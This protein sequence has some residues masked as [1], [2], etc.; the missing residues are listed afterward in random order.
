MSLYLYI[1]L[2]AKAT[3]DYYIIMANTT[4]TTWYIKLNSW[5][6]VQGV[7]YPDHLN[8]FM[9]NINRYK[10]VIM[11]FWFDYLGIKRVDC[12]LYNDLA[13]RT[14]PI[15]IEIAV[16]R[17]SSMITLYTISFTAWVTEIVDTTEQSFELNDRLCVWIVSAPINNSAIEI[18][19][20]YS[21]R[22]TTGQ[23]SNNISIGFEQTIPKVP[24]WVIKEQAGDFDNTPLCYPSYGTNNSGLYTPISDYLL[25]SQRYDVQRKMNINSVSTDSI[26][27]KIAVSLNCWW[28]TWIWWTWIS[29]A[30]SANI[31]AMINNLESGTNYV[32]FATR[33]LASNT[34]TTNDSFRLHRYSFSTSTQTLTYSARSSAYRTFKTGRSWG[35]VFALRVWSSSWSFSGKIL[36]WTMLRQ[37]AATDSKIWWLLIFNNTT[38]AL[39]NTFQWIGNTDAS[40]YGVYWPWY[41]YEETSWWVTTAITCASHVTDTTSAISPYPDKIACLWK[42]NNAWAITAQYDLRIDSFWLASYTVKWVTQ[43]SSSMFV[44]WEFTPDP[45]WSPTVKR[46]F[47]IEYDKDG[48]YIAEHITYANESSE[49]MSLSVNADYLTYILKNV[50]DWKSVIMRKNKTTSAIDSKKIT[51][52]N[53]YFAESVSYD[54][55]FIHWYSTTNSGSSYWF[56]YIPWLNWSTRQPS[57]NFTIES[58]TLPTTPNNINRYYW[59]SAFITQV[60]TNPVYTQTLTTQTLSWWWWTSASTNTVF[61]S[62][63]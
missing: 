22:E 8:P 9:P 24:V 56:I 55:I 62:L 31:S 54:K 20:N 1:W 2:T 38:L 28:S 42:Y 39:T 34:T 18:F 46:P 4:Y 12:F 37:Q 45:V 59:L 63:S 53:V 26:T 5:S 40:L 44:F 16:K 25:T 49:I 33:W 35:W 50:S 58:Y 60:S 3:D 61:K 17:W 21:N 52:M 41:I 57:N 23:F 27:D 29:T 32:Y 7:V 6:L 30:P 51:W 10:N 11:P 48:N 19:F 36:A 15:T 13:T 47:I 43:Y 14:D